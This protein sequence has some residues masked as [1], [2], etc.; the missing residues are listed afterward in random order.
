MEGF[1]DWIIVENNQ[2]MAI[3][4]PSGLIVERSP[5][6][7]P[8]IESLAWDYL[9]A[10]Y[11]KPYLGIVHRLD[12]VTSGVL[13]LA[14][15]KSALRKLN[16]QFQEKQVR[17]TYLAV[18]EQA[19]KEVAGTLKHWL[20]KDQKNKRAEVY[21]QAKPDTAEVVLE[22]RVLK[23]VKNGTLLELHP[24]TGKFHQIR[25]QLAAIGCPIFGDE[26]YGGTPWIDRQILL[27]AW[28]LDIINPTTGEPTSIIAQAPQAFE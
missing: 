7:S 3:H 24:K 9:S 15:R 1:Q 16:L 27:H 6:E 26:K 20:W 14:K 2:W 18:V 5:F 19:P 21:K 11:K 13:L 17:K 4:K 12:R 22:Y 28:K 25:A 23:T 10:Q 8:T